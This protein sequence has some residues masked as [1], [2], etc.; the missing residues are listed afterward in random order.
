MV[1]HDSKKCPMPCKGGSGQGA[2][3]KRSHFE[4]TVYKDCYKQTISNDIL[5]FLS[6]LTQVFRDLDEMSEKEKYQQ[7][8]FV[9][10][11]ESRR[12]MWK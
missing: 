1:W 12:T 5:R 3:R 9:S 6:P 4:A 7:P 2:T 10:Y 8:N 11:P